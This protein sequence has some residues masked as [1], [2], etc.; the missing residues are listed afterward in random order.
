MANCFDSSYP[1]ESSL[2][3]PTNNQ[4]QLCIINVLSMK[5]IDVQTISINQ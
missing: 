5:I 2:C 1:L 4:T 3:E